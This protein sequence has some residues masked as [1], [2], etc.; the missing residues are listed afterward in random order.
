MGGGSSQFPQTKE[1]GGPGGDELG[2]E[3]MFDLDADLEADDAAKLGPGALRRN[4]RRLRFPPYQ[5]RSEAYT[6]E[7][8][9][10]I[11]NTHLHCDLKKHPSAQA[12]KDQ[13]C[14]FLFHLSIW[15]I[16][17]MCADR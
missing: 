9:D 12:Q 13:V 3:L 14:S 17:Y 16:Y 15:Y 1:G 7:I 10:S 2:D 11:M 4:S 5:A 6:T 8:D